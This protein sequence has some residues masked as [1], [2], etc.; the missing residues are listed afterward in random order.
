[1]RCV[2]RTHWVALKETKWTSM[3]WF[4]KPSTSLC[5]SNFLCISARR[6]CRKF[7]VW[8]IF[9]CCMKAMILLM[10]L[11]DGLH[12]IPWNPIPTQSNLFRPIPLYSIYTNHSDHPISHLM[13]PV[14]NQSPLMYQYMSI[15]YELVYRSMLW[16][17]WSVFIA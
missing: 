16:C 2:E 11:Q 4:S 7:R 6:Y 8:I 1:M 14:I 13:Y 10:I 15:S 17:V 5:I 3:G 9:N 12:S